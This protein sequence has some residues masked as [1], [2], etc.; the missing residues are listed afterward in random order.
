MKLQ[1]VEALRLLGGGAENAKKNANQAGRG[2]HGSGRLT[3]AMKNAR[4]ILSV[5][6]ALLVSACSTCPFAPKA[7]E[8]DHIVLAWLKK[9]GDKADQAKVIA[10][11]KELK[12]GIKEV[13]SL[14]VGRA[15]PSDREIVDDS[16]DV[17]LVM[18]F[19]N[20]ADLATYEKHPVHVKAVKE[21]L[22]PL[23][24]Q[25]RVHDLVRE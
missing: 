11:S 8:I 7:G 1:P 24:Q 19:K 14:S 10:A 20:A 21:I 15:L 13:Q 17:A 22:L 12:A 6:A 9:P 18:R 23:T 16:F 25:I 3:T 4:I 5:A 2:V